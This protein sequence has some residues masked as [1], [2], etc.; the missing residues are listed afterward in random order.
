MG[1]YSP[2]E[3]IGVNAV[4]DIVLRELG[5]IFREQPVVDMG[6]DAHIEFVEDNNPTG[7]L[8]ALQIKT[9]ASHF[10]DSKDTLVYYGNLAHLNYWSNHSLPVLLV[11]HLPE[12][13]KTY[14]I[15]IDI[16]EVSRTSHGW[17][18]SI[19]KTNIFG[20]ATRRQLRSSF[21][22]TPV[23]Q[24][25][26]KLLIDEPLMRHIHDG[27]KISVDLEDWINKSLGRT[28][29]K[30]FIYDKLGNETLSQEWF[31]L[32]AGY[33]I[34]E[35]AETLFPWASVGIDQDFYDEGFDNEEYRS[36]WHGEFALEYRNSIYPYSESA[37]EI[38]SYRLE[39]KLNDLGQAFLIVS[40][41]LSELE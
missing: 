11:A 33:G 14:W 10:H 30:V 34:K 26:R 32:Y 24:R 15:K 25:L 13:G 22:G 31:Q 40:D 23:Q 21:E 19:P 38:E 20:D 28:P 16:D 1:R 9:G 4:E 8:I 6:I 3:R 36:D 27:G 35:L 7:K 18:I 37:G 39:L 17:K 12:T 2:T 5:W 29:V 41:H